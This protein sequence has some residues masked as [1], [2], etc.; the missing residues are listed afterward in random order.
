MS[1][2][3]KTAA[4]SIRWLTLAA[5]LLGAAQTASAAYAQVTTLA[6]GPEL[7]Q[8][9]GLALL[10]S[11]DLVVADAEHHRIVRV[12]TRTG[13]VTVVAGNGELGDRDGAAAQAQFKRPVAV[14]YDAA[15]DLTYVADTQSDSIRRID[16]SG[17]VSTFAS[18][19]FSDPMGLTLDS[20]G[21]LYVSDS[22][23]NKIKK[24]TLAGAVTT[25]AGTGQVGNT[26]NAQALQAKFN[27]PNGLAFAANGALYIADQKNHLI[28]KLENGAVT[29]VAGNGTNG[30]V[31]GAA[32]SAKF[33]EPRAIAFDASGS[34]LISD[35][36]NNLV[37]RLTLGTGAAVTTVAGTG[38]VGYV[39]GPVLSAKFR[40]T[41]GIVF[42]GAIFVADP[43]NDAIRVIYGDLTATSIDPTTGPLEGTQ[44]HITGSGFSPD[45]QVKV[46]GSTAPLLAYESS[47]SIRV[48]FPAKSAGTYDVTVT[49][50]AGTATLAGAFTYV[51]SGNTDHTPP[52][53]TIT[54]HTEGQ[55]V[56][57][58]DVVVAGGCDD[59]VSV[60]VNG[61]SAVID[62]AAHTFTI[63][64]ALLEGQNTISVVGTD[65]AGNASAPVVRHIV[66]D[67]RAPELTI[68]A[69]ASC[70]KIDSLVLHG[71]VSDTHLDKVVAKLG[72]VAT[73]ATISG[74]AWTA[75]VAL[76]AEGRKSILVEASD[77][78]GHV[79]TEQ[80]TLTLDKTAPA[81]EIRES[82]TPFTATIVNRKV[83]LFTRATDADANTSVTATLDGAA[84]A[85]GSEIASE[86]S[87]TLHV[88]ATDCAGNEQTRDLTF[89]IDLTAPRFLTFSPA[90]GSKV[91]HV[92]GSLSGT[93][94]TDAVEVRSAD[95]G[96]T[97]AATNG[98]FTLTAPGFAD[99]VNELSLEVVDRAG[100]VG[101]ASYTLGIKTAKPLVEI[102]EGGAAMVDSMVF[103]RSV[104]PEVRVFESNVTA[105]AT[106]DGA[107]FTSATEVTT[108][109][110]HTITATASDSVFGQTNTITRHFTIDRTGPQV[111]IVSPA[112]GAAI[113]VDRTDVRV[114]AGD[115]MSVSVNGIAAVRQSDASWI[116]AN[117]PL[118]FGETVLVAIGR[119]S[120]GN[121]G[122]A[123]IAVNRGG[124]GPALVLTFPPDHYVTNR[125]R[126]EVSGRVLRQGSTVAVTVPPAA[127]SS[128][129]PDAAGTFRLS[130][131]SL[132]EGES[133]IT[134]TATEG[135]TSTSIQARVTADFTAPAVRILESGAVF[136]DGAGFGTQAVISADATDRNAAIAFA[137]TIDGNA[138]TSPVTIT[139]NGG[140]TAVLTARDA[141]GNESRLE[142]AFSVGTTSVGGCRLE[143]FDPPD[144][145]IIAAQKVE[146]IGRSGGAAGVKVNGVAAKMSNGSFCASV[147]LP[148]EGP[149]TV[150][151]ACTDADGTVLG[152]P[153]TIT[154]VRVT[155]EPSVTITTPAE[156][157][158]T[159]DAT[160]TVAGTLGNGAVSVE[161]NGKAATV[162]GSNWTATDVRLT[163]G[164]NVLVARARNNGGRSAIASRRIT[165]IADPPAISISSPIAG[166]VSGVSTTD[167]S[168]T[169]SNVDPASLAVTGFTGAVDPTS[170]SDTT[171]KFVARNVPLQAGDNTV[172]ITGRDR[173]GRL[174]HAEV[175]VRYLATAPVVTI[176]APADGDYFAAAQGETFRV[177]GTFNAAEGATIDVN[178]VSATIDATAKTFFADVT[179]SN[180][181]GGMTPVVAR[182]AQPSGGDGAFDSLR[183]FK[184]VDAPKVLET[185]PAANAFEV[186]PGVVV[187]AL[188]SAPMD[189]ASTVAAFRLENSSGTPVNGKALLD[190]DVLTFAPA[191]T[192]T[193]GERYTIKVATTATDLAGQALAAAVDS[194]FIA[195]T[196]A[197]AQAP[198]ITTAGGR[199][200][201]QLV[202]VA[203][204]TIPGARVRLDYGQIYFTTN[205]SATGAFSYKVPLT[206]QAGYH[207]IRVRTVGAD[208]TLSAAAELKL[209]LD[210]NGPRV[211]RA[212]YDRNVNQ[213]TI[214][215][216]T[217]VK[218]TS[219]T[220]GAAGSIQLVMPDNRVVG[221]TFTVSAANVTVVPAENL[222]A[223][224]FTLKVTRDVED[225]QG[226]KLEQE[227]TQL[228]AL[229]ED[230][231]LQPGEGFISG[232]VFDATTGRPL[233]GAS[234]TIE[235]PTAAFSRR[236]GSTSLTAATQSVTKTTDE[237]GRYA[238]AL[239]E[240]A[241]TI[242]ASANGYTTVWRQII[243]PAGAG[244]IPIDIRLTRRGETKS[245]ATGA[246]SLVNGGTSAVTRRAEL[247]IPAGA[248]TSGASVSL[249]STGA[250]SLA[251]LLPLGWSPLASVE[252]VSS[253]PSLG[254]STLAFD[255]PQSDITAAAQTIAAVRY[256]ES[257]DEWRVLVPV[258]NIAAG[259]ASFDVAAPGAYALVYAD[260]RP[261]LEPPAPAAAG[262]TLSGV[263][264]PCADGT[265]PAMSARS[266]PLSPD[267]VLPT[268]STVAT[269]NIDGSA[270]HRFPSGTA[271]QAYIDEE[272]R[273]ADGG[274]ELP[275]P[276]ATDLLLYRDLA[277]NDGVA[278]FNLAPSPRAAEVFLEVG[279]DHIRIL[280]Y[281]GRLDRGTLIGPEG[282]RVPA[283]DKVAVEIPTGATQDALR[284][285][286]SSLADPN[287]LGPIAGY[288]IVGGF[289]LTLE[290]ASDPA[291][292][293]IDGD[294]AIDPVPGVELAKPARATFT[295]DPSKIPAGA[296]QL[297]LAELLEQT[298]FNNRIFR[299]AAEM[300]SIDGGR[301]TTKP[302][303]RN[304]L[305]VD[306]VIR[307]GRY[308]LLAANAPIAFARGVVRFATGLAA[309]DARVSTAGLGVADL[310]RVSGIFNI[311]VPA[312]PAAPFTLVP[313]T[314]A[315]GDG[316]TYTHTSAP[317]AGAY[318]NIGDL[319]IVAQPPVV[320][321]T[322]PAANALEV[323]IGT[324]VQITFSRAIDPASAGVTVSDATGSV[325]VSGS[326][327][328]WQLP[329]GEFLKPNKRYTV[330]VA[331]STR[332]TNGAPLT[333]PHVFS[334]TTVTQI[335]NTEVR[336]EKIRITIPDADGNA[337]IIGDP[338]AL[339]AG[340]LAVPVR[341]N[342]DFATRYQAQAA[343]DGSFSVLLAGVSTSDSIDL[344][345]LNNNGALSA[346][347]PLAVFVSEDRRGFIAPVTNEVVRFTSIDGI[348]VLV[349]VGAFDKP[350]TITVTP[351]AKEVFTVVPNF[352]NELDFQGGLSIQF[353]GKAKKPLEIDIPAPA[354]APPN[355]QYAL[356]WLGESTRGP[357][358]MII[359]TLRLENGKLTTRPAASQS[360][361]HAT[362]LRSVRTNEVL[363]GK[364]AKKY[365]IRL[366]RAGQVAAVTFDEP[367]TWL[368]FDT[369][370]LVYGFIEFFMNKFLALYTA[371]F[372]V[373]E[374]GGVVMPGVA[375]S[376]FTVSGVD[377]S[378]G[379]AL[380]N[381]TYAELNV[382]GPGDVVLID[383]PNPDVHGP[384]PVF[385]T[386]FRIETV[387][388]R[389]TETRIP[390]FLFKLLAS[391]VDVTPTTVSLPGKLE[392]GTKVQV[393]NTA[394]GALSIQETVDANGSF[395]T[396][397]VPAALNDRVVLLVSAVDVHPDAEIA[398]VFSEAIQLPS[399]SGGTDD[400]DQAYLRTKLRFEQIVGGTPV[401]MSEHVE[402]SIDSG[403]RRFVLGRNANLVRGGEY[404]LVMSGG[405]S[406]LAGNLIGATPGATGGIG[407]IVFEFK[408]RKPNGVPWEFDLVPSA[409]HPGG[410]LRDL[411][412]FGNIAFA[413][414]LDGGLLAY[415][416]DDPAAL[417]AV[418]GVQPKPFAFVPG[419]WESATGEILTNG[420][421]QHWAVNT[422]HH[423]RVYSTGLMGNFAV[424]RSYRVEDFVKASESTQCPGFP[425]APANALCTFKGAVIVGWRPGSSS[426]TSASSGVL[427]S[428]RPEGLP[429]KVQILVQDDEEPF[430][431]L[432][433]FEASP[434][435]SSAISNVTTYPNDQF[436][437][438]DVS[439]TY[440]VNPNAQYYISQRV[441]IVNET[442]RMRW[443]AD[444]RADAAPL[445]SSPQK[446]TGVIA[447]PA[448]RI[449]VLRN[450]R[451]YALVTMFGYGLGLH[452]LNAV[453][454]ND[455]PERPA[456]YQVLSEQ[457]MITKGEAPASMGSP[458]KD[459]AFSA[460]AAVVP[461]TD[462]EGVPAYAVD[463]TR[464]LVGMSFA[465]PV[466]AFPAGY[467]RG[468]GLIFKDRANNYVH[469]RLAE[470]EQ[471]FS[472]ANRVPLA[473]FSSV[474]YHGADGGDYLVVAGGDY[475]LLIVNAR[476]GTSVTIHLDEDSLVDVIWIPG[477]AQSVRVIPNSTL[478]VVVDGRQ[479]VVLVDLARIDESSLVTNSNELFPT[480]LAALL[481]A[482]VGGDI[483]AD[484]PRI[485]WKSVENLISG[486][487]PPL[488]DP[489][490]GTIFGGSVLTNKM[491]GLVAAD[492]QMRMLVDLGAPEG[493]TEVDGPTPL[494]V[495]PSTGLAAAIGTNPNASAAA[496]RL[497]V[498]LPGGVGKALE[499][500]GQPLTLAIESETAIGGESEQT[501]AALP[502]AHLRMKTRLGDPEARPAEIRMERLFPHASTAA[503]Q[504][505]L[506]KALRGQEG[507]SIYMSPWIVAVAEPR[508]SVRTTFPASLPSDCTFCRRP[509]RIATTSEAN[510]VFELWTAGRY[511]SV[512]PGG[513]LT[514]NVFTGTKYAYLG[515][516]G[517]MA[518]RFPT[519][520]ADLV[521]PQSI[522]VAA[523][524]PPIAE[525]M[526]AE[527]TYLHSGE[528]EVNHLDLEVEGRAGM[529]VVVERTYRSRTIGGTAL[530]QNW[531]ASI[532]RRLRP[533]PNG[534]VEYYDGQGEIWT[535]GRSASTNSADEAE[536]TAGAVARYVPPPG[537]FLKLVRTDR[538]FTMFDAKWRIARFDE[539]GR[540]ISESDEFF[541]PLTGA[542]GNTLQYI[543]DQHGRLT[544]IVDP[545]RRSLHLTY[546]TES[547]VLSAVPGAYLS[548]L[549][550]IEDWKGRKVEYEYDVHGRLVRV[551][552]PEF[553]GPP[554]VAGATMASAQF[555]GTGSKRPVINYTYEPITP[556]GGVDPVAQTAFLEFFGN[557][558]EIKDPA[559]TAPGAPSTPRVKFVYDMSSAP[560]L[561][562]RVTRQT[563]PCAT[564]N[565]GA[566]QAEDAK[567]DYPTASQTK[568]TDLLE[569]ERIY[570]LTPD[571]AFD[572]R[573]HVDKVTA[574]NVATILAAS[575]ALPA[576][577]SATEAIATPDLITDYGYTADGQLDLVTSPS[578]LQTKHYY[579]ALPNGAPGTRLDR[580]EESGA[581]GFI[582]TKYNYDTAANA[583]GTVASVAR[584][585]SA[586]GAFVTRE[587]GSPS[588]DRLTV[589][590]QDE[591]IKSSN[592]FDSR[593][594]LTSKETVPVGTSGPPPVPIK[595]TI[596]YFDLPSDPEIARGRPELVTE[597]SAAAEVSYRFSY[598]SIDNY[599]SEEE[600][601]EDERRN[602]KSYTQ[603]DAYGRVVRE[604]VETSGGVTL[605]D[606]YFGYDANGN[607][608][609][610]S[611]LQK[612]VGLVE[613]FHSY[614]SQNR[615]IETRTTKAVLDASP[616]VELTAKTSYDLTSTPKTVTETDPF[617]GA[618]GPVAVTVTELDGL[619]RIAR[620]QR[621]GGSET[622]TRI[623]AHDI[624]GQLAYESD[625]VRVATLLRHDVFGREL[626]SLKSDG[627]HSEKTWNAW[628]ELIENVDFAAPNGSIPGGEVA[629]QK[630]FYT[631]KG[632]L[633][634]TAEKMD[635]A[636]R[637]RATRFTWDDGE[638]NLTTRVGEVS[639]LDDDLAPLAKVR[640]DQT[641]RDVA[642]RV[643]ERRVGETSG[644]TSLLSDAETYHKTATTYEGEWPLNETMAEPRAGREFAATRTF[645][646][647]GRVV[648]DTLAGTFLTRK[649]YDE[650]GNVTLVDPPGVDATTSK[651]DSRGLPFEQTLPDGHKV[652]QKF[653]AL[654][655]VRAYVDE[656]D[657]TT[658][659]DVDDLG[660]VKKARFED[661]T[662]EETRYENGTGVVEA[663]RDRGGQWLSFTYDEAGRVASVFNGPSPSTGV[664]LIRYSYDSAGRLHR[665]ADKDSAVE[666]DDFDM[667]GHPGT[668]RAIRYQN[669]SG[670]TGSSIL[671]D[672]H[673]QAHRWS[674]FD[675]RTRWRMPAA[676]SALPSAE[677][678]T[679]WRSWIDESY[680][681]GGNLVRQ[682]EELSGSAPATG[683]TL[684]DA[685]GRGMGRLALRT[686]YLGA[687]SDP[688]VTYFGYNDGLGIPT[689]PSVPNVPSV[690]GAAS[691]MLGRTETR[692]GTMARAGSEVTRDDGMR[693]ATER[694]LGIEG[695]SSEF[696]YEPDR[697]RLVLSVLEKPT[698]STSGPG[699]ASPLNETGFASRR[700]IAGR[701][702]ASDLSDLGAAA[703]QY[704]PLSWLTAPTN[705]WNIVTRANYLGAPDPTVSPLSTQT[706][707][708][709]GG[710]RESDERWET[711]YDERS[712]L[713]STWSPAE[714]RKID[715]VYDPMGHIVGRTA[716]QSNGSGGWTLETRTNVL[717]RDGL[718]ASTTFVW[719]PVVE[720]LVAVFEA[721]ASIG[722]TSAET[723]LLRQYLHGDQAEDDPVEVLIRE[724]SVVRRFLP[725]V[726]EA[727]G[728]SLQ[729]VIGDD[730]SVVERVLYADAYGDAPRYLQG[731]AVDRI[732]AKNSG[733]QRELR[734]HFTEEINATTLPTGA[735]LR[736]LDAAGAPTAQRAPTRIDSGDTIVWSLSP[737]DW[738]GFVAGATRVEIAV[739]NTLRAS[740]WGS[741]WVAK[742]PPFAKVLDGVSFD[743]ARGIRVLQAESVLNLDSN[744]TT[745]A[746]SEPDGLP[747]YEVDDLYLAA[748]SESATKLLF[749]FHALPFREPANKLLYA[750][751]R[752]Y[753]ASTETFLTPDPLGYE[754]SSNL[755]AFA[756]GDPVNNRDPLG[757]SAGT[758]IDDAVET[759]GKG[760]RKV[761]R[762]TKNLAR[763]ARKGADDAVEVA[764]REVDD[765]ADNL[766]EEAAS[767]ARHAENLANPDNALSLSR[768]I[769]GDVHPPTKAGA[770]IS[771][772]SKT[773]DN[774]KG[775]ADEA[776]DA[777]SHETRAKTGYRQRLE[778]V[779]FTVREADLGTGTATTKQA[780]EFARNLGRQADEAGH[781]RANSHG[782]RGGKTSKNIY[783]V[784][785]R[786]NKGELS[787]FEKELTLLVR[788]HG[789]VDVRIRFKYNTPRSTRPLRFTYRV[790]LPDGTTFLRRF[791]N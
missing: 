77:T 225:T 721:G 360:G 29:T 450:V 244:V 412:Q 245:V 146:L 713:V 264:D 432:T 95:K 780:R 695:R 350:T 734:V 487:L 277:G 143:A 200:C 599:A 537:L 232:E 162:N 434:L 468:Y 80:A 401:P 101:R 136:E 612:D 611:R 378:T 1:T 230:E 384:T 197:P 78:F 165:Y 66:L 317:A 231:G 462:A 761:A 448:D 282:G 517:R 85:S 560:L 119:D 445:F 495:A 187:L 479:R 217:D 70:T 735:F 57:A 532:F 177:S 590:K 74:N 311:P 315:I 107:P 473:R 502:R 160:I 88:K 155:N 555:D 5:L 770:R 531:D 50:P 327:V 671:L 775:V 415:Y 779:E 159:H 290:R 491:L 617:A 719:D 763:R 203:G 503:E 674:V 709:N 698:S 181:P 689:T 395:A 213:L 109:G 204:T 87:H 722:A 753:D 486:T 179:F 251:G 123:N 373:V 42:A 408:V 680:D 156:D 736:A 272:L 7:S 388:L 729:A 758:L 23:N 273:L 266:F 185:F 620:S 548:L 128:V 499:A 34:L 173:T 103:T 346:I 322:L 602:T 30:W 286:A 478:A 329:P 364:D 791:K 600:K 400:D 246:V 349:P 781:A 667:V 677:P 715:Y 769:S 483:G 588:R 321:S 117:V 228:F 701:F 446:V 699:A 705:V 744:F 661:G 253:A 467:E 543:Y 33:R 490:T 100:N 19:G 250:Q 237:R 762:W 121:S 559:Q 326:V 89:T 636:G 614:D 723:G 439:F 44:V 79:A 270:A 189:R 482:G 331:S 94:D 261:G 785:A 161:L 413:S 516:R 570:D 404:R 4:G 605:S 312:T 628:D 577:V 728:G 72:S 436:K 776:A 59:A 310:S 592:V 18:T 498:S 637:T 73:N 215:F 104:R 746:A 192:L 241:H 21:N 784:D 449:K 397:S 608:A 41:A 669:G 178:G 295:V 320:L 15:R 644:P 387:D 283:D 147:E 82:G 578:G 725:I 732:A 114:T 342:R 92:P 36:N 338:G 596:D 108:G 345:V 544:E 212:S 676:G 518:A 437:K 433:A 664:E 93:V 421:D 622:L 347:I 691:G 45:A 581:G 195:S 706:F 710:R 585:D 209:S 13:V 422:D 742:P 84:W 575:S 122:S 630:N 362:P 731:P 425:D 760:V 767:V 269:L 726:D 783:P 645:D 105:T 741:A 752:W 62:T 198:T 720:R 512:R 398:L 75:T 222:S 438:F 8:P 496:F 288:T 696:V 569:Q 247:T 427:I 35:S 194:S 716:Y 151:I 183:V 208:G 37:R 440:P 258:A 702:S 623:F 352:E 435:Y 31:D 249:T 227:H 618:S 83:T 148:Q 205:A 175:A 26:D 206:G 593:G 142:R 616:T 182:L 476:V 339:P 301:W 120:A 184:L 47:T 528:V 243:V 113:D 472:S 660:R 186:D 535:F 633:R 754:D 125:P 124:V 687:S 533:L 32:L 591:G 564:D 201:A 525:G 690:P 621:T 443:S 64:L 536:E 211:L 670:L 366:A 777:A 340:W 627:T 556:P 423:G 81:I 547:D 335:A 772:V 464:G 302:I 10:P 515:A 134:A 390:N 20:A 115:A 236:V 116:A 341:R 97:T 367:V 24:I 659:Y 260:R 601:V 300:T 428:D 489:R 111:V 324:N 229:G 281:P 595:T 748:S 480:A 51:G 550:R 747:L 278:A 540:L 144:Q 391:S 607:L 333:V 305:P 430:E 409:A 292:A 289:Q 348:S 69:V 694:D 242:R 426:Y 757:L 730:G 110:A 129:T 359:D 411:A 711:R 190:K 639:A 424:L 316:A 176:T 267:V 226:R 642:G 353:E 112:N 405:L 638:V 682:R 609:Y 365:L 306:G 297:I 707:V 597:G 262:A 586:T 635:S 684:V 304:V 572:R 28:R 538:G 196:S 9:Y 357:R 296:P 323:S 132:T 171:G 650:E 458:V 688:L 613:T 210:C 60:K 319:A 27:Q 135:G 344:R 509:A 475:G 48:T 750:R 643:K 679:P 399:D 524:N 647:L 737:A 429:R 380:F 369:F 235:V 507:A 648:E 402:Y 778:Q 284:A 441:T 2:M 567:F 149:N 632:R 771:K 492:P 521:R 766:A 455:A 394:T 76:G 768:K 170:W 501:P 86:G 583:V 697:G 755:Y 534:D 773:A 629:R 152:D 539:L 233:A 610:T 299:L 68:Q 508:A 140:H 553:M 668:T 494:G 96:F 604:R 461:G 355:G 510:G 594:Q 573:V 743:D 513:S 169:F 166:F 511:I 63:P 55:V 530:G 224:T 654:G 700:E 172:V 454:S 308:V 598:S 54:S 563:W 678:D 356:A 463:P 686:R 127:P 255:V 38:T 481:G 90:S 469:P 790:K 717:A 377:A 631:E 724:G 133:T 551:R 756:A 325:T 657:K 652:V 376:P 336:A 332:G 615:R 749:D 571:T 58:R 12:S 646:A 500:A 506:E 431:S 708:F 568:V 371:D 745:V 138:V 740:G 276:F 759:V 520:M 554:S 662:W 504:E 202:D 579:S 168:G 658:E 683:P 718:P 67:S 130:G 414:A 407:D 191:T 675:E 98:A 49:N 392:E 651:Y 56:T 653:D 218:A 584:R 451:T 303:D 216:S 460:E 649:E 565:G 368:F 582:E 466:G 25:I 685:V 188:F 389:S 465:P 193:P 624:H 379:M 40:E 271:V 587:S 456:S 167:I 576:D 751:A 318:V 314:L 580:V 738:T 287:A 529:D 17:I 457:I 358:L 522:R 619:A 420:F 265:C 714:G 43:S 765:L 234:V 444:I 656:D 14:A 263:A 704:Q 65:A 393:L 214:V 566:C 673:T 485:L 102:S 137:L 252:I 471:V 11:G 519:V 453:E 712:R 343:S 361:F 221:A 239:P 293:D 477:G 370:D 545:N 139:A 46:G 789:S 275:T 294:G 727:G 733:G 764:E 418:G 634:R 153:A 240:G 150:T 71:T 403:A 417:E 542:S 3:K 672:V 681:G 493:L 309:R 505:E 497:E 372:Y 52:V 739:T 280:P 526:L 126:I 381:R 786:L 285:T 259:K 663:R 291:P 574:S 328:T 118:D 238:T 626:G 606:A 351:A 474:G 703:A 589:T 406:D 268:G 158:V 163:D 382:G 207:V 256:D 782:G 375:G 334:F 354:N 562:D 385:A 157:F 488:V 419:R 523:Q 774:L 337:T 6:H 53:V 557:L 313:R 219:L 410:G 552:L 484:D 39:D 106:L 452:D 91:T 22:G 787:Q 16:G 396:I 330:T 274:R 549:H 307:E 374:G 665:V 692:V 254:A 416:L 693:V 220:A 541:D 363:V 666:L 131:A 386:P 447:R 257:R 470:I 248:V 655:N 164:I 298:P 788:E 514:S 641:V 640:V 180:L 625:G 459:L 141:A 603:R 383:N 558:T 61:A 442:L 561:R 279:F 145:S 174:A 99:G 546:W 199:I 154:L 527:T 223:S